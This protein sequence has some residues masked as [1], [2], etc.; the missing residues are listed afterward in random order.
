[1]MSCR[2]RLCIEDSTLGIHILWSN[3]LSCC[4]HSHGKLSL[5]VQSYR[6]PLNKSLSDPD[7][8]F[9]G[10]RYLRHALQP[11]LVGND[12]FCLAK[13]WHHYMDVAGT[14]PHAIE[15]PNFDECIKTIHSSNKVFTGFVSPTRLA[16][17]AKSL[18]QEASRL[19][20]VFD[21]I[22]GFPKIIYEV[23][24]AQVEGLELTE[25]I[26]Y[27]HVRSHNFDVLPVFLSE[28]IQASDKYS[29]SWKLPAIM[30]ADPKIRGV[31]KNTVLVSA[32]WNE[33]SPLGSNVFNTYS[34]QYPPQFGSLRLDRSDST[35]TGAII[36]PSGS[37]SLGGRALALFLLARY[38]GIDRYCKRW[39]RH[40]FDSPF[41]SSL[42]NNVCTLVGPFK[43]ANLFLFDNAPYLRRFRINGR[44]FI[45]SSVD[46]SHQSFSL[47]H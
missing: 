43:C 40:A 10:A 41:P 47:F 46:S 12:Y 34:N 22:F 16:K 27:K 26:A 17:L 39:L 24:G 42:V 3:L 30:D 35:L 1:M 6:D 11:C 5:Y 9:L 38:A 33:Y 20:N 4:E 28:F 31:L 15:W 45:T 19:P 13:I 37:E 8:S 25:R 7:V 32:K 36:G 44:L 29:N 2:A 18:I 14:V 23:S 21:V